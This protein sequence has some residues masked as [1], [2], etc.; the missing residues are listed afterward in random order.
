MSRLWQNSLNKDEKIAL[1]QKIAGATGMDERAVEKDWWVT[2]A[3]K[4]LSQT[5]YAHLLSF[6]GGTSISIGMM[7]ISSSDIVVIIPDF[8]RVGRCENDVL[9]VSRS[10]HKQGLL[11]I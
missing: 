7:M 6:K 1:S 2:V 11:L 5:Q 9:E 10:R 3:L 8:L 4:A